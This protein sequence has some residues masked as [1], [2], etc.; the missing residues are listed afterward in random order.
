MREI[1]FRAWDR[2]NK[3]MFYYGDSLFNLFITFEG[4]VGYYNN[5]GDIAFTN[6]NGFTSDQF[7]LMQFTGLLDKNGV[8]IYEG[9][10][11]EI[12]AEEYLAVI[13]WDVETCRFVINI[14]PENVLCDFD[15]YYGR[16]LEVI[17]NKW[18][19]PSLME[20]N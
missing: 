9:D 3:K 8:E 11:V 20:A 7:E 2:V 19:N 15:N 18:D 13:E 6:D 5:N 1:K 10:I 12:P 16:E 17:S 4:D 14:W